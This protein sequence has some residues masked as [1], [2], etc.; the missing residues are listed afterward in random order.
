M[1]FFIGERPETSPIYIYPKI[2]PLTMQVDGV[3]KTFEA[4][5]IM[6]LLPEGQE[7][8]VLWSVDLGQGLQLIKVSGLDQYCDPATGNRLFNTDSNGCIVGE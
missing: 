4:M 2:Q 6:A 3:D 5:G 8:V 1:S 7:V